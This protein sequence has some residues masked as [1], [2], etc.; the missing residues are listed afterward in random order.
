MGSE[1]GGRETAEESA[2]DGSRGRRGATVFGGEILGFINERGK[3][4]AEE[5][6][7]RQVWDDLGGT[8]RFLLYFIYYSKRNRKSLTLFKRTL[9]RRWSFTLFIFN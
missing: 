9:S 3:V 1:E 5:S 8:R 6:R 2:G 4:R 7:A